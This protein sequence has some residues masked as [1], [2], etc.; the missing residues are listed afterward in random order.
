MTAQLEDRIRESMRTRVNVAVPEADVAAL[1][2]RRM[3]R[4]QRRVGIPAVGVAALSIAAIV[5]FGGR[6]SRPG[7]SEAVANRSPA[8][9]YS[10]D[11]DEW[12]PTSMMTGEIGWIS[13]HRWLLQP[14]G[15]TLLGPTVIAIVDEWVTQDFNPAREDASLGRTLHW[16]NDIGNGLVVVQDRSTGLQLIG[17]GVDAKELAE[18]AIDIVVVDGA[19]TLPPKLSWTIQEGLAV[20]SSMNFAGSEGRRLFVAE[21]DFVDAIAGLTKDGLT[22]RLGTVV[23]EG[24]GSLDAYRGASGEEGGIVLVTEERQRAVVLRGSQGVTE[25]EMLEVATQLRPISETTWLQLAAQIDG[26]T[27]VPGAIDT[28]AVTQAPVP[29]AVANSGERP[30]ASDPRVEPIALDI[31]TALIAAGDCKGVLGVFVGRRCI[32]PT[33]SDPSV[34]I[35]DLADEPALGGGRAIVLN[36][37]VDWTSPELQ[38]AS[39]PRDMARRAPV[40][41]PVEIGGREVLVVVEGAAE[42]GEVLD[43]FSVIVDDA[44][45]EVEFAAQFIEV[46]GESEGT[47]QPVAGTEG[48]LSNV[49]P[50]VFAK[51]AELNASIQLSCG[52][53]LGDGCGWDVTSG[54]S[55]LSVRLTDL[56]TEQHVVRSTGGHGR[57]VLILDNGIVVTAHNAIDSEFVVSLEELEA[58]ARELIELLS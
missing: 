51:A 53:R 58:E 31:D 6:S 16:P 1:H 5:S 36:L 12:T 17:R 32:V 15:E 24:L 21:M 22:A 3:R 52:G 46:G 42:G 14:T 23:V 35:L 34:M 27:A 55:S 7:V 18:L 13:N 39:L 25:T 10:V 54:R 33:T 9:G 29:T 26:A 57:Q 48:V 50:A 30:P 45:S 20:G 56:S 49:V 28:S 43:E 4:S 8:F 11:A 2:R 47:W 38:N 37:G 44:A 19:P 40:L 41:V